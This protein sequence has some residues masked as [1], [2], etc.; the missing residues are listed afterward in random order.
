MHLHKETHGT[1]PKYYSQLVIPSSMA[2]DG[3]IIGEKRFFV[4]KFDTED[5]AARVTDKVYCTLCSTV[6]NKVAGCRRLFRY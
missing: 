2:I 6:I 3:T 4:G 5:E 1:N